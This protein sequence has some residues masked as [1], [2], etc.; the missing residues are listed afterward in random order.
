M[1][2]LLTVLQIDLTRI[3]ILQ[4]ED[5]DWQCQIVGDQ[6]FP[7][8]C[9]SGGSS[10]DP[11]C[12]QEALNIFSEQSDPNNLR[13]KSR[14]PF[15]DLGNFNPST[16]KSP[17]IT[18]SGPFSAQELP[19]FPSGKSGPNP[20]I[21]QRSN[22]KMDSNLKKLNRK[23]LHTLKPSNTVSENVSYMRMQFSLQ[24]IWSTNILLPF[25]G[26]FF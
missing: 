13:G 8:P 15:S 19:N 5:M 23:Q 4:E 17:N 25:K 2:E 3:Q 12:D 7:D 21:G 22:N 16:S 26:L 1:N 20:F 24:R 18:S 14:T 9:P 10:P 11:F 6:W